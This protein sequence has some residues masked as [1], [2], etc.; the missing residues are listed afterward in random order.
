MAGT[1]M[2]AR[3]SSGFLAHLNPIALVR[4]LTTQREL[5]WQF[6]LRNFGLKHKG[7]HLGF[8]WAVFNPLLLLGLY[9]VVFGKILPGHFGAIPNETPV[10]V[11]LALLVG[12]TV[13]HFLAEIIGQSPAIIVGNVNLV[14]KVVF[15]L[16]VLPL[17]NLGACFFNFLISLGL[18]LLGQI[19]FGRGLFASA[20]W[21]IA[22]IPP[23]VF[24]GAGLAWALAALGVFFRDL[25]QFSQFLTLVLMYVSAVFFP[26]AR[27]QQLPSLWAVLRFNPVLQLIEMLRDSLLWDRPIHLGHLG[28][29]YLGSAVI[30]LVGYACFAALRSSF[31]DVL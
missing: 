26:S 25:A 1:R 16:E 10:D 30:C 9:F 21:T 19:F 24:L 20:C 31:S 7:T 11:A 6:T 23:V 22:L 3:A 15:P 12:L 2:P 14:K 18:V 13:F 28:W 4:R 27:I 8:S 17:A 29:L 5:L